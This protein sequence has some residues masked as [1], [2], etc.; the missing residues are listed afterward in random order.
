M[1]LTGAAL[2][3]SHFQQAV[4]VEAKS[5]KVDPKHPAV[6]F[7]VRSDLD[8]LRSSPRQFRGLQIRPDKI[9]QSLNIFKRISA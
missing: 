8:R 7:E 1:L 2:Y 5:V 6:L 9:K 4:V 3:G